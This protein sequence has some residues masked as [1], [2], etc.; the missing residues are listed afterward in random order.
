MSKLSLVICV[1][2][3][4]DAVEIQ[5]WHRETFG[6][7]ISVCKAKDTLFDYE[8]SFKSEEEMSMFALMFGKFIYTKENNYL[9]N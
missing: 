6:S 1:R 5:N 7:P 4:D 8:V 3:Y 2:E 9:E